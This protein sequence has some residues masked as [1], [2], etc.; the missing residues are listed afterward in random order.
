MNPRYEETAARAEHRC[1]YCRAPEAVFNFPFE[2]EHVVPKTR[3]GLDI[4]ANWALACRS[5]NIYKS[6][7]LSGLDNETGAEVP[8]FHPRQ[9]AWSDHFR[10]NAE[11][12]V[13]GGISPCGRATVTLLQMNGE[14]QIAARREWI[15]LRL[16]HTEV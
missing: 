16:F 1:E 12:A 13:I 5:C 8:L 4:E 6:A 9:Q 14:R 3:G 7:H 11:T 10:L 2:V 15:R